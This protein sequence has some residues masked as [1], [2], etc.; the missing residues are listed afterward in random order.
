MARRK[1]QPKRP[2]QTWPGLEEGDATGADEAAEELPVEFLRRSKPAAD[3][4]PENTQERKPC[5][6]R[7]R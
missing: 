6:K 5:R 7:R 4:P 1:Q 3:A 2:G